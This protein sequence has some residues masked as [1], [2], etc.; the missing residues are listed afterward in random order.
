MKIKEKKNNGEKTKDKKN[1]KLG[2]NFFE[3]QKI[4]KSHKK[5]K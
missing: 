5:N 3:Y 4:K 1:I 2:C